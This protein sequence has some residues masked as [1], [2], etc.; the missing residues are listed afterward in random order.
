MNQNSLRAEF[1]KIYRG[2]RSETPGNFRGV[3]F[4]WF[5]FLGT[6]EKN[7][8]AGRSPVGKGA[9]LISVSVGR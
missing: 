2:P 4:F 9:V 8:G 7:Q 3:P 1:V 6:Q 5:L